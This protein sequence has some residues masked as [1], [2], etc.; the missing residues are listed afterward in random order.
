MTLVLRYA[1]RSDRGLVR[2]SNQDSVYAGPRLLALAD[3]MGGHAAGEVASK[4]VIASLAPLDDD[5]PRDDLLAQLREA[6]A[7]GNAAIAELVSQDPDLDGMGTTLT[8][9]LFAGTRLGL[10]HVGDSRAYLL[11]GGQFA[12]ITRD[13]SFVN[14]LLEQ[15]RIT[16]EEAAV[17]PQRS[18][19]LKALTG[20]EVEP[21][22][23]VREARSGDRY[24]IC[25]DGLSGMVS[26]ETLAEA[27]QIPDPQQ[28][29]DRMIELALKGGGTDNVT[30]IIADVVDVDFGEDAPIVGGAAGDGSDELHQGDSPAARARA[31]TQPPP[32]QRPDLP[33]PR[34]DPKAKRR[35][36]FRWLA[37]ALVVLVVLAAAAIATRYFVL[38]QYYVGEGADGEVVIYRGVPGSI[39]GIDL[40][41]YEQ[42]SCPPSQVCTDKLR[43]TQ[44]QEDARLAVQ[45]GVKKD[46]LDEARKYIDDFLQ[47][48]KRLN[49][50]A[51]AGGQPSTTPTPSVTPTTT[52]SAP[53][54]STAPSSA[55]QPAGR[56]CSTPSSTAPT[57]GGGN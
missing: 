40:H 56:D 13:D 35:K 47:L 12:Q 15:G 53:A 54:G 11:R 23:T 14:E 2:S 32:Q 38:S 33:Q 7:N 6:V 43:V 17:H 51:P 30:V 45:N 16:P 22:L 46:N 57:T 8:A 3:G 26:D 29:A 44:L 5:E 28:C 1:A 4:V 27:V 21:S 24:L 36:R 20:H 55:N 41:A 50:C 48:R 10:V 34:E 18:L 9:V 39:L 49:N 25:S 19:L 52:P 42:G 37:G 31:L